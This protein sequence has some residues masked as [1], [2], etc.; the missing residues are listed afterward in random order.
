MKTVV[1]VEDDPS[2]R[3]VFQLILSPAEYRVVNYHTAE[4][5]INDSFD[6]PDLFILDKQLSG[7][8]GLELC[9]YIKTHQKLK[10]IPVIM[11]SAAPRITELA[12]EAGADDALA[13]P[14]SLR[15]IR[16]AIEQNI[17]K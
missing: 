3:D 9:K 8:D 16:S 15:A 5:I 6:V 2:I 4:K 17:G 14:F 7:M 10:H 12:K 11:L 1:L 13:K